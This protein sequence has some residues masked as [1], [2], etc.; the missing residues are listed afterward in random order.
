MSRARDA[1]RGPAISPSPSAYHHS[2]KA[3]PLASPRRRS[4]TP[5]TLGGGIGGGATDRDRLRGAGAEG[6]VS[7]VRICEEGTPAGYLRGGRSGHYLREGRSGR[8]SARR[9]LRPA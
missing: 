8:L 4:A 3:A 1:V 2:N 5:H 7:Q 6:A 9:A